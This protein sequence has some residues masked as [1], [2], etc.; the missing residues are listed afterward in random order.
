MGWSVNRPT[1]LTFH[2]PGLSTKGY[3]LLTP[4]GDVCAY[5]IDIDGRVVHRWRFHHIK[6]GYGRLL[7]N[8]NLLMTGSD[9]NLAKP[10]PDEPTVVRGYRV[11]V[12]RTSVSQ[13]EAQDRRNTVAR[14][15]AQS[16]R[17]LPNDP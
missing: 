5:L 10:P 12:S 14:V 1:G 15:I 13:A 3:T 7:D 11:K 2:R 6:P 4:H 17:N 9:V 8:G 16:M